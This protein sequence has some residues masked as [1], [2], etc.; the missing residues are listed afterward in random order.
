MT[1]HAVTSRKVSSRRSWLAASRARPPHALTRFRAGGHKK[2]LLRW[3]VARRGGGHLAGRTRSRRSFRGHGRGDGEG[4]L[5]CPASGWGAHQRTDFSNRGVSCA[6][7]SAI[8]SLAISMAIDAS[9]VEELTTDAPPVPKAREPDPSP[10]SSPAPASPPP[11]GPPLERRQA[12]EPSPAR[13]S[14]LEIDFGAVG[15][16]DALPA[17]WDRA[18]RRALLEPQ[19]VS[20]RRRARDFRRGR[21]PRSGIGCTHPSSRPALVGASCIPGLR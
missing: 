11:S 15:L 12:L 19:R 10:D 17:R 14:L 7:F 1:R 16:A 6:A 18:R 8:L 2:R 20:A 3:G 13:P 5:L 4:I 21:S 9:L